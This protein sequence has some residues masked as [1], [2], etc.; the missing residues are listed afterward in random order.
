[1]GGS[2]GETKMRPPN[3]AAYVILEHQL[4]NLISE[5]ANPTRVDNQGNA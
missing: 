4:E 5:K 1:V 3:E 2:L